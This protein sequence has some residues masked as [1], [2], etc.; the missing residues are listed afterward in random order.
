MWGSC[1]DV[2]GAISRQNKAKWCKWQLRC[3]QRLDRLV[4]IKA[5]LG[6]A[7]ELGF[8]DREW[9]SCPDVAGAITRQNKAR[10]CKW[11]LRCNQRLDRLVLIKASLGAARELG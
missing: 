7:R 4:L 3:N 5:S 10:L 9:G 11:Q 1:P 8:G 6:A 2:A